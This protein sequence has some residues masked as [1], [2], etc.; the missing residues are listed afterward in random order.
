MEL[1]IL[2][3]LEF[4]CVDLFSAL[5]TVNDLALDWIV[6]HCYHVALVE[7]EGCHLV[8]FSSVY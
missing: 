7:V 8:V 5:L 1:V 3:L 6:L 2:F 4:D